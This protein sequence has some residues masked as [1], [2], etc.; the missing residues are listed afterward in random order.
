MVTT[1]STDAMPISPREDEESA[2]GNG[3]V[4]TEARVI[5]EEDEPFG[6]MAGLVSGGE[7]LARRDI[8]VG[9]MLDGKR[10]TESM[11]G[12]VSRLFRAESSGDEGDGEGT[13]SSGE[14]GDGPRS[15]GDG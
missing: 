1:T 10:G 13:E 11:S 7:T 3:D 14:E 8:G 2:A 5:S 15:A 6:T 12:T 4:T 9:G